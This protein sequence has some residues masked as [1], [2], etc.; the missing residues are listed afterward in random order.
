[1]APAITVAGA[2]LATVCPE[3]STNTDSTWAIIL[4]GGEGTRLAQLTCALHGE[5]TPKQFASIDGERSMLQATID[6]TAQ[7]VPHDRIVVVV[8]PAH[9]RWATPQLAPFPDVALL[10]QP[11]SLGTAPAILFALAAI[12][13]FEPHANVL[14]FPSDHHFSGPGALSAASRDALRVGRVLDR[15]VLMGVAPEYRATDLGWI[16]PGAPTAGGAHAVDRFVEKP[17][18]ATA[19]ALF[20]TGGL[21]NT[22]ILAGPA[23]T[24]VRVARGGLPEHAGH[25][26]ELA[27]RHRDVEDVFRD[28]PPADFSRDVLQRARDLAVVPLVGAG[29]S[30]WGTPER[31]LASLRGTRAEGRI[32]ASLQLARAMARSP[33]AAPSSHS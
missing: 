19:N 5:P 23:P 33:A 2:A 20:A 15:V 21:W 25:F 24:F 3:M 31:V 27:A 18:A 6:R 16:V 22:F 29:W 12:R 17:D 14:V 7:I 30:D 10:V 26:D 4:A 28:L 13:T 11:A 9:E 32:R 1:M 8:G